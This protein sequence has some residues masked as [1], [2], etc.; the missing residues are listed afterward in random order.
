[1]LS[2]WVRLLFCL[3]VLVCPAFCADGGM[4]CGG[5]VTAEAS[6][7][8]SCCHHDHES[9]DPSPTDEPH[10]SHDSSCSHI[11]FC[12]ASLPPSISSEAELQSPCELR[13]WGR[14]LDSCMRPSRCG[15]VATFHGNV[16][17]DQQSGRGLLR[18]HCILLI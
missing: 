10:R 17:L 12:S 8:P 6:D 3:H 11:C 4:I 2:P 9:T 13:F 7:S 1:V 15:A 5:E 16:F 14:A 18:A